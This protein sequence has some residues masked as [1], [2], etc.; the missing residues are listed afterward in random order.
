MTDDKQCAVTILEQLGGRGFISMTG[1]RNLTYGERCLKFHLPARFA[2]NN[3]R[4]VTIQLNGSDYYDITFTTWHGTKKPPRTVSK[5][6]DI[7]CDT[8]GDLFSRETGLCIQW[9]TVQI[10]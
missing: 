6:E 4:G 10:A 9:P 1:A 8:Q 7:D 3:I 2:R 5:H